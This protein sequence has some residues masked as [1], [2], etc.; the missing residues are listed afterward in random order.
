MFQSVTLEMSLKPFRITTPE[1]IERV[2]AGVFEQ[3]KPLLK[4]RKDV[5]VLLWASDGS[6]ILDYAGDLSQRFESLYRNGRHGSQ[7]LETQNAFIAQ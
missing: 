5:S 2:C 7:N 6:E 3:W 1:Y 4:N